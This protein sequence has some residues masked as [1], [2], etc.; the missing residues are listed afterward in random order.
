MYKASGGCRAS[1]K[2][3]DCGSLKK[4]KE[5]RGFGRT[6]RRSAETYICERHPGNEDGTKHPWNPR[7]TACRFFTEETE[8]QIFLEGE[9]GQLKFL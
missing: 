1:K 4:D 7:Y 3:V 2:C 6:G 8:K 9:D 5:R